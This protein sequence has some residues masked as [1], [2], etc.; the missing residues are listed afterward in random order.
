M[1]DRS[2]ISRLVREMGSAQWY[3]YLG[4]VSSVANALFDILPEVLIG[5]AINTVEK[6]QNSFIGTFFNVQDLSQQLLLLGGITIAVFLLESLTDY[7]AS[8]CWIHVCNTLQHALR[9]KAY[10][11]L[12]KLSLKDIEQRRIGWLTSVINEDIN[13][14]SAFFQGGGMGGISAIIYIISVF[15]FIGSMFLYISPT[16]FLINL[17]VIPVVLAITF[18]Y[19]KRMG[20][21]QDAVR[22]ESAK[23]NSL[24]THNLMGISS[25]K[26]LV[27]GQYEEQRI[28]EQ[29]NEYRTAST[30]EGLIEAQFIPVVR[31]PIVCAFVCVLV[32]GGFQVL[33]G[34]LPVSVYTVVVFISQRFIWPF[35]FLGKTTEE[36]EDTMTSARRI[37]SLIDVPMHDA[38]SIERSATTLN[39][40]ISLQNITFGYSERNTIFNDLSLTIPENDTVAFIGETGCGKSTIIKLL[41]RFYEPQSGAILFGQ[42]KSTELNPNTIRSN[43]GLVSQSH[44]IVPGTITEN[45]R[46]GNFDATDEE[47]QRAAQRAQ[48]DEFVSELPNGYNTVI[49]ERGSNLSGGQKQRVMIAR[50]LV[51]NPPILIFDEATS[52]VDNQTE[53]EIITALRELQGKHTIILIAHRLNGVRHADCIYV[54]DE[55]EIIESGTHDELITKKGE[56]AHSWNLQTG[57]V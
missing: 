31:L 24:L 48:L 49:D 22:E 16:I 43:I 52:A 44:F 11:H 10:N 19:K 42:T 53:G 32:Y 26:S 56:Y 29:S 33:N 20:K 34:S 57:N 14:M 27:T 35:A 23:T 50:A 36:Y 46:Y 2:I 7:V 15:F 3:A 17:T 25:I 55:G 30:K 1:N 38:Y 51:K 47:I 45:I 54:L 18:Y 6:Q 12:Q 41:L 13:K 4:I 40:T 37:F 28:A 8:R 5:V 39:K 21:Y 9:T